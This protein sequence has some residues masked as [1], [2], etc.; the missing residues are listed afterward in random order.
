MSKNKH[1]ILQ[2][3]SNFVSIIGIIGLVFTI[4]IFCYKTSVGLLI[5]YISLL[6]MGLGYLLD[7][8]EG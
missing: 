5:I 7:P 3:I 4:G 1:D 6:L 8:E 2:L